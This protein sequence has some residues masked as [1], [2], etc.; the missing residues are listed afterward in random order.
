MRRAWEGSKEGVP[1]GLDVPKA[2]LNSSNIWS[3]DRSDVE[4]WSVS[5]SQ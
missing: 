5:R 3:E 1:I 4:G 2:S